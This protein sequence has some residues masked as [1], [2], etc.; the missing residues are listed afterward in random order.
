MEAVKIGIVG[1]GNI[2]DVYFQA[3]KT[4]DILEVAACADLVPERAQRRPRSTE[5]P[6]PVASMSCSP[7]PIFKSSST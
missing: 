2:S 3:G 1:C 6:K 7:T 4:F 5:S